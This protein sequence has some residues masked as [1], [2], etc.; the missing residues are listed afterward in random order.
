MASPLNEDMSF[1]PDDYDDNPDQE[2]DEGGPN[3]KKRKQVKRACF[4]C[5]KA[6]ARTLHSPNNVRNFVLWP[7]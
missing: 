1:S 7:R 4:S 3:H 6:H 5:R 2:D